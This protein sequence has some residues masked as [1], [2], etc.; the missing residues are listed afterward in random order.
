MFSC[1]EG[2]ITDNKIDYIKFDLKC[3]ALYSIWCIHLTIPL[4]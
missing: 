2:F 4:A 3:I 1:L